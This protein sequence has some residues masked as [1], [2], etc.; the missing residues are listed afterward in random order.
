MITEA[1]YFDS[2]VPSSLKF[3]NEEARQ[4]YIANIAFYKGDNGKGAY[5]SYL[6]TTTDDPPLSEAAWSSLIATLK[7]QVQILQSDVDNLKTEPQEVQ[8]YETYLLFPTIGLITTLYI[9]KSTNTSYRWDEDNLKYYKIDD[10][11][12]INGGD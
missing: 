8:Q 2:P 1:L 3:A 5:Q 12:V 7:A 11:E 9:D 10:F 4:L 6:E